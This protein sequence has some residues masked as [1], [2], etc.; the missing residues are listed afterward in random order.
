MKRL[1]MVTQ[2]TLYFQREKTVLEKRT[3]FILEVL[4]R[5]ELTF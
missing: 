5:I 2:V 1:S 4:K 3:V